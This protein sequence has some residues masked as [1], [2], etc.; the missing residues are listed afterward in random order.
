LTTIEDLVAEVTRPQPWIPYKQ[1]PDTN[2]QTDDPAPDVPNP[3]AGKY[4]RQDTGRSNERDVPIAVIETEDD[5]LWGVWL[6]PENENGKPPLVTKVWRENEPPIGSDVAII[7]AP[8]VKSA[9]TGYVYHPIRVAFRESAS[10]D[11]PFEPTTEPAY[12]DERLP[13]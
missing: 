12:A 11:G 8:Q 2:R 5:G 7:S 4:L 10:V 3:L 1:D 13:Y 6:F 9:Q